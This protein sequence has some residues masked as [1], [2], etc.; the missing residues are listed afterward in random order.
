MTGRCWVLQ[1]KYFLLRLPP[2]QE[3]IY[4][5][6]KENYRCADLHYSTYV[7]NILHNQSEIFYPNY[8]L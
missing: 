2:L 7:N 8:K 1:E 3:K 4:V 6:V 5:T